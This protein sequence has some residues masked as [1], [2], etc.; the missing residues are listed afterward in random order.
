MT[1]GPITY[2]FQNL[3]R[4]QELPESVVLAVAQGLALLVLVLLAWV[5]HLVAQRGVVRAIRSLIKR[6]RNQR[7]DLLL[8]HGVFRRTARLTPFVV[9][10]ITLPLALPT[11]SLPFVVLRGLLQIVMVLLLAFA[12]DAVVNTLHDVY[13][14]LP[15][16]HRI[17][18]QSFVQVF[19]LLLYF[20]AGV[21]VIAIALDK[22]PLYL[23][24]GLGALTAVLLLVFKDTVLGFVAGIQL[25][26]NRMIAPGDWIE[27]G[28]YGADGDVLEVGLNT[29]KVQN[30]D[31]TITT[32]PTYALISEAFR[33]WRGMNESGGR[34]LKRS[35]RID[36]H[37]VCFCDEEMLG[38]FAKIRFI[39]DYIARKNQEVE[40]FN[41]ANP[42]SGI[43]ANRRRLT[44]LG[45]FRAYVE[46]FLRNHP[47]IHQ[48]MTLMVRQLPSDGQGV[49][50][51][52]Y[53]FSNDTAWATYEGIMADI[54]DHL[55]AIIPEFDLRVFQEPTGGDFHHW[56]AS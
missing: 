44:N 7:D 24:S 46:G 22:T 27:M 30:W 20:I 55:L 45:T 42:D 5:T 25:I 3:L 38:R 40:D 54:F 10:F 21:F 19:K 52:I 35:V 34:R 36:V 16:A 4:V 32:I 26:A 28:Q 51:E 48:E 29:V 6:T 14:G 1:Q 41:V 50:I 9:L 43:P 2:W 33:N 53:A 49:P 11:E 12:L 18:G 15:I 37:S 47:K 56:A 17:T 8:Q 39:A 13:R 31:M 23:L